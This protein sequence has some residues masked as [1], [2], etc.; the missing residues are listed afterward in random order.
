VQER[1]GLNGQCFDL[2]KFRTMAVD[3]ESESPV[4]ASPQD[5][6]VFPFG[7]LL[8]LFHLDEIPQLIN[9]I[10]GEMSFVGPRPERPAFVEELKRHIPFY[11]LRDAVLPGLTGWA[12]VNYPYGASVDDALEKLKYDLYYIRHV[13]L[14]L[15]LLVILKTIRI[16]LTRQGSR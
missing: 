8:R 3:S 12:Q 7:R 2:I 5:P 16:V 11:H 1:E 13:S 14:L 10:R 15:D 4:W 6:R 9:V